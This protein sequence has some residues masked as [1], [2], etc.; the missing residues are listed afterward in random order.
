MAKLTGRTRFRTNWRRRLILQ[1]E[2]T[3]HYCKDLNGS[4]Y[5]DEWST[6]YWR[7]AKPE[8]LINGEV[9]P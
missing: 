7:D 3:C 5:Y 9:K 1:V 2:Y 4:G 6:R 8:D